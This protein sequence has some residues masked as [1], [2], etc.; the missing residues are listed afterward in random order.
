MSARPL[1]LPLTAAP[2]VLAP[3]SLGSLT[4]SPK[5]LTQTSW[6]LP[7]G[8]SSGVTRN[9]WL[10]DGISTLLYTVVN[11]V[12]SWGGGREIQEFSVRLFYGREKLRE[13]KC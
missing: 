4:K 8:V 3:Y 1:Q 6:P 5:V 12:H 9:T 10:W 7:F 2:T 11:T 13:K